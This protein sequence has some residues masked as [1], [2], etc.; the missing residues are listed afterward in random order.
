MNETPDSS[1]GSVSGT[2]RRLAAVTG[3]SERML[4]MIIVV[5][6]SAVSVVTGFVLAHYYS[7]DVLTSL[8]VFLPADCY[9]DWGLNVGRHCFS[10]YAIVVDLGMRANPWDPSSLRLPPDFQQA[11][12]NYPAAGMVPQVLFGLFGTWLG[13]PRIGLLGYLIVLTAAVLSPAV[14]AARGTQGS[15]RLLVFVVCGVA[16]IPA[17]VAIDRGNAVGFV[18]PIALA[19]LIAL[20]RQR[21]GLSA[22]MVVLAALVKP[23]FAVLVVVLFAA[24]QWRA[25]GAAVAGV[26]ISNLAA[27]LLWP[28]DFPHTLMQSVRN[29]VGYSGASQ[30][31]TVEGSNASFGKALL[32][33][34]DGIKAQQS[35][36]KIP[37]GFLAETRSLIG[38]VVLLLVVVAVIALGRRIP[39]AMA[40]IVVL[41]TASL[42]PAL[43]NPYYLV[44]VL[45]VAAVVVRDPNGPPG[46]GIFDRP[47]TVG[48]RRRVVGVVL[49]VATALSIAQIPLPSA[50][51]RVVQSGTNVALVLVDSTMSLAPMLW[52]IVLATILVSYGR[53]SG[54]GDTGSTPTRQD[55]FVGA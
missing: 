54:F 49:A 36:G 51:R 55:L 50:T 16:A 33:I 18:V 12:S 11:A 44:F 14:W 13:A 1:R 10:D 24:R 5:M 40:G 46:S 48:G 19:F 52:L 22:V 3:Q 28:R 30:A 42:F 25:G 41:A 26:F 45:P 15:E 9:T 35:G 43:S 47:E 8:I 21:W 53:R 29:T 31:A 2:R 17:W 6:A 39:P 23:Q 27:Y 34:P 37:E 38:Y 32:A 4:F 7:V 20:C